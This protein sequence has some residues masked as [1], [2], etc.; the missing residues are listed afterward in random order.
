MRTNIIKKNEQDDHLPFPH[1][2]RILVLV[3]P[4]NTLGETSF[5]QVGD[6]ER[7]DV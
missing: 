7:V 2:Y 3:V 6:A 5:A 1:Y 4:I